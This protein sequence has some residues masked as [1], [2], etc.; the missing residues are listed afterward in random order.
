MNLY[1]IFRER[2]P[3]DRSR[4]FLEVE[5]GPRAGQVL[6]YADVETETARLAA[7]LERLGAAPGD[8]VAAQVEK[9]PEAVVLYLACLRAGFVFVPLNPAYRRDEVSFFLGDAKPAV[10]ACSPGRA[11]EAATGNAVVVTLDEDGTGSLTDGIA[12]ESVEGRPSTCESETPAAIL[13]TSGTTGR[14]KGAVLSHGNLA[15]NALA[16]HAAWGFGPSDVLLHALPVFHAHGLFVALNTTLLNGTS[17]RFLPRFDVEHVLG[18]LPK[19]TLM[20]GVPTHYIRLLG[21]ERFTRERCGNMRLF[22]SG[23]APLLPATFEKFRERT[24]HTILERY[25]M[26]E[27]GMNASNPLDGER[28]PGSVGLPLPGVECRVC[29]DDGRGLAAGK[30]GGLEVR[31]P[32]VFREYWRMPEK[33]ANEFRDGNWFITGDLARID[34]RGYVH[35]IGRAKDLVISGGLNVFPKEVE[36]VMDACPGVAESAVFGLPDTD[37]GE[38]VCA[39]V[40]AV[41]GATALE[42]DAVIAFVKERLA[43]FKTPK[44]VFVVEELPRNAMG[45]VQKNLLREKYSEA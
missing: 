17:M 12:G 24:G 40:V 3:E 41:P 33:T 30:V 8:R 10:Y 39:A 7:R 6:S 16:L 42:S 21:D 32:N 22:I 25:G 9:S 34:E 11:G 13:Y 31:G 44:R 4:P 36:L 2:F 37:F 28:V 38:A 45:K 5:G 23:S 1:D 29:D 35:L 19:S 15:S 27:T 43:S 18:S 14:S 26:T 20:M